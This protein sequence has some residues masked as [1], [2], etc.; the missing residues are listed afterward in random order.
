MPLGLCLE[1]LHIYHSTETTV[2]RLTVARLDSSNAEA[3]GRQFAELAGTS[4]RRHLRL[5]LGTVRYI[6][7]EPLGKLVSL[8]RQVRAAGGRLVLENVTPLVYEVL[9]ATQLTRLFDVRPTEGG[10][11]RPLPRSA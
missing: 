3:L 2:A 9:T 11:A 4:G 7:S 10:E 6:S 8:Y 5:D 1:L